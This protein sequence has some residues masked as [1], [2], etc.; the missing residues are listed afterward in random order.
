MSTLY[1][2]R[3]H[4]ASNEW[5]GAMERSRDEYFARFMSTADGGSSTS[6]MGP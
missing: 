1:V 2:G 5:S 4:L 3:V 6:G